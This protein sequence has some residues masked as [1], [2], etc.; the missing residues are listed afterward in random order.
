MENPWSIQSIYE[1]Q[2]FLCPSCPFKDHSKQE[3][4]NHAY[5]LHPFW[6]KFL[7]K[8]K[9]DSLNEV[10]FPWD[11]I[12]K[13]IKIESNFD[14]SADQDYIK[15]KIEDTDEHFEESHFDYLEESNLV[16]DP[17]EFEP[18][19]KIET[20][21]LEENENFNKSQ[22]QIVPTGLVIA[23]WVILID[24]EIFLLIAV[25]NSNKPKLVNY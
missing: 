13:N 23:K 21:D 7:S 14:E 9:D 11:E 6:V 3:L 1:L 19:I 15:Y 24:R 16:D 22:T 4:I 12:I 8:I 18:H 5:E 10:V 20:D 2:Y 17:L 25:G